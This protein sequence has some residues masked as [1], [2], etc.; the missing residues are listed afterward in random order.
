MLLNY[1]F[2][3]CFY[4]FLFFFLAD[5]TWKSSRAKRFSLLSSLYI[6]KT[7]HYAVV[8]YIWGLANALEGGGGGSR[9][10]ILNVSSFPS[11]STS[12]ES[13]RHRWDLFRPWVRVQYLIRDTTTAHRYGKH[14][15]QSSLHKGRVSC[16]TKKKSVLIFQTIVGL[17]IYHYA[18]A[19][20]IVVTWLWLIRGD[21]PSTAIW[22]RCYMRRK[23]GRVKSLVDITPADSIGFGTRLWSLARTRFLQYTRSIKQ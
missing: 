21:L 3:R 19:N 23:R 17:F 8:L 16:R 9:L 4:L 18:T 15:A 22:T 2:C 10:W 14:Y 13:H 5:V 12:F 6:I 1:S 7:S 20:A 11:F